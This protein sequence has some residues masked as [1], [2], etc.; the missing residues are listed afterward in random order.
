MNTYEK[1]VHIDNVAPKFDV[2]YDNNE[3]RNDNNY[4]ADRTEQSR[5]QSIT[6]RQMR[7]F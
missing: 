4:K 5:L 6:L 2:I 7:L 1:T 3:A